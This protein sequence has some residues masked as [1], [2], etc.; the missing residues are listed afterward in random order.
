MA[1]TSLRIP[2][3]EAFASQERLSDHIELIQKFRL[4]LDDTA[5][6][7][8]NL[9]AK[10]PE[11]PRTFHGDDDT[12]QWRVQ[13]LLMNAEVRYAQYLRLLDRRA[14]S[15]KPL[16]PWDVAI[17]FY[18]HLLAPANFKRD[19]ERY[20]PKLWAAGIGFPLKKLLS[21]I[22]ERSSEETWEREHPDMPYEIEHEASKDAWQELYPYIPYQVLRWTPAGDHAYIKETESMDI[23]GYKCPQCKPDGDTY[24]LVK[25]VD[26]VQYRVGSKFVIC[27]R[28]TSS[29]SYHYSY[30]CRQ[31]PRDV[32]VSFSEE[33]FDAPVF[34]LWHRPLRQFYRDGFAD[35]VLALYASQ[36]L[37]PSLGVDRYLKFLEL[38]KKGEKTVVPT[39]DIDLCWHT[40]QLSPVE[41]QNYS[42]SYLRQYLNHDDTIQADTR[43]DARHSTAAAWAVEYGES[44]YDPDNV[45]KSAEIRRRQIL[46]EEKVEE[47]NK[48]LAAFDNEQGSIMK[49]LNPT[50]LETAAASEI[51]N[52]ENERKRLSE[53][54]KTNLLDTKNIKPSLRLP[55]FR[56]YS[57]ARQERLAALEIQRR[58]LKTQITAN[59]RLKTSLEC[60]LSQKSRDRWQQWEIRRLK[61]LELK[62]RLDAELAP[63]RAEFGSIT[64]T[65][66]G[67][68]F[69]E[70]N[71]YDHTS[72][73]S[74]VPSRVQDGARPAKKTPHCST[75]KTKATTATT[76]TTSTV[77]VSPFVY[78]GLAHSYAICDGG[79]RWP[80]WSNAGDGFGCTTGISGGGS[81]GGGGGSGGGSGGCGGGCGGGG[82][83]GGG[84]GGGGF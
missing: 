63:E 45:T 66:S 47:N 2:R 19:M 42:I 21:L 30:V 8:S 56:Y 53:N 52:L 64:E 3:H 67:L 17:I 81:S 15:S 36:G 40:H 28:G 14:T 9:A 50:E 18:A 62:D 34:N 84:C 32:I 69:P 37:P 13:C 70:E 12:A 4:I 78:T 54:I 83:G 60:S 6:P 25:M 49:M 73:H 7:P 77:G 76:L 11:L 57:K 16:P 65:P 59:D 82:G 58:T 68:T 72:W 71:P 43:E 51:L 24:Q 80:E 41:Y 74:I 26:W 5:N 22:R 27:S 38:L 61:R 29:T 10:Y 1:S 75:A 79:I 23:H 55:G 31:T 48:T 44:Y 39:L 20:Y 35:R 46:Y 33:Q